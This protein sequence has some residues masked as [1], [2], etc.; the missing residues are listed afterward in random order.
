MSIANG[1][2]GSDVRSKLNSVLAT[3]SESIASG[4]SPVT[5]SASVRVTRI[6]SGGTAGDEVVILANLDLT[7]PLGDEFVNA[8]RTK[9]AHTFVL[10]VQTDPA[11]VIRVYPVEVAT[12]QVHDGLGRTIADV[13]NGIVLD[14]AGASATF[15]WEDYGWELSNQANN[16]STEFSNTKPLLPASQNSPYN[17]VALVGGPGISSGP[18][19]FPVPSDTWNSWH[20]LETGASPTTAHSYYYHGRI[21]TG[22]TAGT[23]QALFRDDLP[24]GEV[25]GGAR[26]GQRYLFSVISQAD[27]SDVVSLNPTCTGFPSEIKT[28][29]GADIASITFDAVGEY[30]LVEKY[31]ADTWRVVR[32]T[33]TVTPV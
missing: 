30:L 1:E 22:G 31:D 18:L 19:F 4:A 5:A 25:A 32:A 7:A 29:S 11:D 16:N 27:P 21:I 17:V 28:E 33:A 8:E 3:G 20:N 2:S 15:V 9:I 12:F 14:Y 6:T 23:E 26:I 13:A 10:D 24:T